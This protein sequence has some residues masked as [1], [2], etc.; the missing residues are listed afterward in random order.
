MLFGRRQSKRV[1]ESIAENQEKL[2][3]LMSSKSYLEK[4]LE[5]VD[6]LDAEDQEVER[7]LV[8]RSLSN[9]NIEIERVEKELKGLEKCTS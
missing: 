7:T 5:L 9:I 1:K 6:K 8:L 3:S 2:E 4:Q